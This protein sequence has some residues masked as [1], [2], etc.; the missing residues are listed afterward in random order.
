MCIVPPNTTKIG[1]LMYQAYLVRKLEV[2]YVWSTLISGNWEHKS[3]S[4]MH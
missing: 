2:C 4:L 1:A 3:S